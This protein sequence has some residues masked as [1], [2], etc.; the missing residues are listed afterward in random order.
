MRK[1]RNKRNSFNWNKVQRFSIRKLSFGV[2]LCM[3]GAQF[4]L[5]GLPNTVDAALIQ[6]RE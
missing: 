5:S 6:T 3:I 1:A 4:V 2:A